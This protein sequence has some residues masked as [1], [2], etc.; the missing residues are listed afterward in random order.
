MTDV[1][2]D[3][4]ISGS[5]VRLDLGVHNEYGCDKG[6]KRLQ[7]SRCEGECMLSLK[8]KLNMG[9]IKDEERTSLGLRLGSSSD[10][11]CQIL[12]PGLGLALVGECAIQFQD[13]SEARVIS[14]MTVE[15]Q[16]TVLR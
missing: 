12:A 5:G 2:A 6:L 1:E 11:K 14:M 7:I 9:D 16:A 10:L 8:I 15:F 4:A 3:G 13:Y